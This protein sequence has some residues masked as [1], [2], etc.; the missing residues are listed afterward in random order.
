MLT[1]ELGSVRVTQVSL[2]LKVN[3]ESSGGSALCDRTGVPKERP[4]ESVSGESA[5]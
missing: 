3:L 1:I 4:G 5:A 2:D